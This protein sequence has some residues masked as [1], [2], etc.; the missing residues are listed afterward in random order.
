VIAEPQQCWEGVFGGFHPLQCSSKKGRRPNITDKLREVVWKKRNGD[1]EFG[2]CF[3]CGVALTQAGME[4]GHV[5]SHKDG[6]ETSVAN[7]EPICRKCNRGMGDRNLLDYKRAITPMWDRWMDMLVCEMT[8]ITTSIVP[9]RQA[10]AEHAE[11]ERAAR[12]I[13]TKKCTTCGVD[14]L[15]TCF[16]SRL[17]KNGMRDISNM[18]YKCASDAQARHMA[19]VAAGTATKKKQCISTPTKAV[20]LDAHRDQIASEFNLGTSLTE[21]SRTHGCSVATM[22]VWVHKNNLNRNGRN[23]PG[24]E[25]AVGTPMEQVAST[26]QK[27]H[28]EMHENPAAAHTTWTSL[29]RSS[30]RA[31]RI[32]PTPTFWP[33]TAEGANVNQIDFHSYNHASDRKVQ[34]VR[35]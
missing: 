6:G 4:C 31:G 2:R 19:R 15:I 10:Y 8:R 1:S 22:C 9:Y 3:G 26:L 35:G 27:A 18:C 13:P 30:A 23:T 5:I 14:K 32:R 34:K 33:Q 24:T 12:K 16:G 20:Y 11:P 21:L 28:N 29:S 17:Q 25:R 7:L